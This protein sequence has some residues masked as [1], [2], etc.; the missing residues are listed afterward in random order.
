MTGAGADCRDSP[1]GG[2]TEEVP[3]PRWWENQP[4]VLDNRITQHYA[5]DN[6]DHLPRRLHRVT[7]AGDVPVGL[8]GEKSRIIEG[9]ASHYS[10]AS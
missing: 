5:I 9:D 6:Y 2:G 1:I 8:S 3:H 7:V 4:V 10:Q